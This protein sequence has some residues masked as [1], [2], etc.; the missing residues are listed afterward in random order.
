MPFRR[1]NGKHPPGNDNPGAYPFIVLY[2]TDPRV[3]KLGGIETAIAG[4]ISKKSPFSAVRFVGVDAVGDLQTG[5]WNEISYDGKKL[6]FFPLFKVRDLNRRTLPPLNLR[7]IYSLWKNKP[8]I[9]TRPAALDIHRVDHLLPFWN[10]SRF[11]VILTIHGTSKNIHLPNESWVARIRPLFLFLERIS[12]LRADK[13]FCVSD[14]GVAYYR[15]LLGAGGGKVSLIEN[16]VDFE[17]FAPQNPVRCRKQFG[18]PA[19][20][21]I[22]LFVGRLEKVKDP[23][24]LLETFR[25]VRASRPDVVLVLAGDGREREALMT[26]HADLKNDLFFL[27]AVPHARLPELF[28]A[29]DCLLLTSHFEGMPRAVLEALATGLPVVSTAVGDVSKVVTDG[30]SGYVVRTR[31][32]RALA[33]MTL[34]L[35]ERRPSSEACRAALSGFEANAVLE[36]I[37]KTN[38][39]VARNFYG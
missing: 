13:I 4:L 23:E 26:R 20:K 34:E 17:L 35:L 24:L 9:L 1:K 38:Q 33:E 25:E 11:P 16:G 18:L 37:E 39:N 15:R 5:R 8:E 2:P 10:D 12:L 27:G 29:A 19:D 21:K 36:K 28:S 6:E 31:S 14:E 3:N 22:L 32:P 7:F 30:I